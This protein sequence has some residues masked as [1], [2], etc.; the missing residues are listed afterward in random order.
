ML[1]TS[2][3]FFFVLCYSINSI[4][5]SFHETVK[6]MPDFTS[7]SETSDLGDQ[8]LKHQML[9]VLLGPQRMWASYIQL[10]QTINIYGQEAEAL[11][12]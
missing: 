1:D 7:K 10:L 9:V 4:W 6:N 8:N 2:L 5:F 12:L 3:P 11:V